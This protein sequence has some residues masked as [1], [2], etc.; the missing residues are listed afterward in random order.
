[1]A[2]H[3][4]LQKLTFQGNFVQSVGSSEIG[5]GCLQF[6]APTGITVHP[7][8]GQIFIADTGNNIIVFKCLTVASLT[9]I[10]FFCMVAIVH[11][12]SK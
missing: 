1:M 6:S 8:T 5:I 3:H 4:R 2:D 10:V 11:Y 9:L 7:N 12:E